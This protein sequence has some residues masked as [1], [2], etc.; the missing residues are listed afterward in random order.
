MLLDATAAL[1]GDDEDD[2][3]EEEVRLM[4]CSWQA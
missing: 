1:Q 2:E 3:G 4:S